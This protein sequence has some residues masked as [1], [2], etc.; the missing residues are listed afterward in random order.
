MPTDV[1]VA[2][3]QFC[4]ARFGQQKIGLRDHIRLV[5]VRHGHGSIQSQ[6]QRGSGWVNNSGGGVIQLRLGLFDTGFCSS[7][8]L[9]RG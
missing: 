3:V 1:V 4:P 5:C 9:V 7:S 6:V 2:L 8:D